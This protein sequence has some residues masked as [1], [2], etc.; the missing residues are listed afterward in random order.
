MTA[1]KWTLRR[2]DGTPAWTVRSVALVLIDLGRRQRLGL[3]PTAAGHFVHGPSDESC[4]DHLR[5]P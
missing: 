2:H 5:R 1:T 4:L 3:M